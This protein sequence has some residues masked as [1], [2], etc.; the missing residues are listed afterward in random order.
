MGLGKRKA[1][2]ATGAGGSGHLWHGHELQGLAGLGQR[3]IQNTAGVLGALSALGTA[4]GCAAELAQAGDA[5]FSGA[6][7][8]GI[9]YCFTDTNVHAQS[10]INLFAMVATPTITSLDLNHKS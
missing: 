8:I 5:R 1:Q 3:L 2:Q 7:D 10:L 9:G 4:A 6:A